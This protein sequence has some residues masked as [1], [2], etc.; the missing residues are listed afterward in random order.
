MGIN[1]NDLSVTE[2][3]KLIN[4]EYEVILGNERTNYPRAL[5]I[6]EK[7]AYL[8]R[9]AGHGEWRIKLETLCPHVSYETA[10]KYIRV[11]RY[12]R[13]IEAAADAKSVATTDLTIELA[14]SLIAKPKKKTNG[15]VAVDGDDGKPTV[16]A[17]EAKQAAN[18]EEEA[19]TLT[20]EEEEEAEVA[21]INERMNAD[22]DVDAER[23]QRVDETFERLMR[24]Y[25]QDELLALTERL[26][27]HLGMTLMP[28]DAMAALA[29]SLS[30]TSSNDVSANV[31]A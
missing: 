12:Q 23:L 4:D 7:L 22:I 2:L 3:A 14:L 31:S 16:E 11:W 17:M 8:R 29:E 13:D 27:K 19:A 21:A 18:A 24:Y 28:L 1:Y 30:L 10:T 15:S 26:A 20:E 9:G 6:G 25:P 5:S